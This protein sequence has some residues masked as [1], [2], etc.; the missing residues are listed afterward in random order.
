LNGARCG[1]CL[2]RKLLRHCRD[3][4]LTQGKALDEHLER[5]LSDKL[6]DQME[7]TR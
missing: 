7:L 2:L 1:R 4:I 6:N 3:T 5:S